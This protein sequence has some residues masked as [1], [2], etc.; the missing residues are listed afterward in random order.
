MNSLIYSK[1]DLTTKVVGLTAHTFFIKCGQVSRHSLTTVIKC[2]INLFYISTVSKIQVVRFWWSGN[3]LS[4]NVSHSDL[5]ADSQIAQKQRNKQKVADQQTDGYEAARLEVN[6][7][8]TQNCTTAFRVYSAAIYGICL[9]LMGVHMLTGSLNLQEDATQN[10]NDAVTV[11]TVISAAVIT[12]LISILFAFKRHISTPSSTGVPK[13]WQSG[14]HEKGKNGLFKPRALKT[15][16]GSCCSIDGGE[17][18]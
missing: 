18:L 15:F 1:L 13:I 17:S 16:E 4:V 8:Y 10:K 6:I 12:K 2:F 14:W 9:T 3:N 5:K 11:I 7:Q